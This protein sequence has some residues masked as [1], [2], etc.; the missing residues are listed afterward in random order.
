MAGIAIKDPGLG[1]MAGA[2][3]QTWIFN[4]DRLTIIP[5]DQVIITML[6]MPDS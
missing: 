6:T 4:P 5:T 1:A 3:L 2:K